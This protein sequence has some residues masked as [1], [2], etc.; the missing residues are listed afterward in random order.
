MKIKYLVTI[1]LVM[2]FG[3]CMKVSE[4]SEK[5]EI[6]AP[7]NI[8]FDIITDYE[9]YDELLPE[10]HDSIKI[11]SNKK[12]GLGVQWQS[13]GTFKNHSFT[14]TWTITSYE[15]NK[16]VEMKDLKDNLGKA[17][18]KIEPR[19]NDKVLYT[20]YISTKMYAPYEKDFFEIYK[21][22]MNI[23]KVE[24]ERRYRMNL[25]D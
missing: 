9:S 18:F 22:E 2:L 5:I 10:L 3:S 13:T 8:V 25:Y 1:V 12:Q 24:A 23:V 17:L 15:E 4:F 6:N 11:I 16:I 21:R 19:K 20:M 14:T 7:A